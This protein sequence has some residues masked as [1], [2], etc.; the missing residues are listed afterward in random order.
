M[1]QFKNTA[2]LMAFISKAVDTALT[3]EVFPIIQKEELQAI[4]DVVYSQPTS[5]YYRRRGEYEGMGDPDNI[6]IKGGAARY[7][8]LTVAN[9]TIP[10]AYLNGVNGDLATTNKNLLYLIEYGRSQSGDPGYDY[11]SKPKARPFT[12]VTIER[13]K[14][15][16]ACT[17]ALKKGLIKQGIAVR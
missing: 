9:V 14:S 16:G 6:I 15:S 2:D 1:P 4:D 13:L 17:T 11:W 12:A 7:G 3:T 8:I 10:N 5:G